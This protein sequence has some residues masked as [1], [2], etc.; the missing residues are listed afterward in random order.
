M[1]IGTIRLQGKDLKKN[2][3]LYKKIISGFP[4]LEVIE[5]T[6]NSLLVKDFINIDEL[7]VPALLRRADNIIRSQILD[8]FECLQ[9]RD[10]ELAQTIK[11]RDK[12]INRLVFLVYKCL[13]YINERPQEGIKHGVHPAYSTHVWELN[14]YLEKIG[15]EIKRFAVIVS[16]A[17]LPVSDN[18][19]IE[20][21]LRETEIFY[22]KTMTALYKHDISRADNIALSRH[23]ILSKCRQYLS[24]SRSFD[25][26]TI[27]NKLIYLV[28]FINSI[29]RIVRYISFEKQKVVRGSILSTSEKD[30]S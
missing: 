4:G 12:E 23:K 18:K 11:S 25:G 27:V 10:T 14:G 15:D 26:R 7:I 30:I 22:T 2:L 16:K 17:K 20:S 9:T 13:N 3:E 8:T 19:K 21:L 29:S 6:S 1:N 5:E 28:S 24:K